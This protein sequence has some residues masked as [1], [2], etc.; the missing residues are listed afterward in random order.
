[1]PPPGRHKQI[2]PSFPYAPSLSPKENLEVLENLI[3]RYGDLQ[4]PEGQTELNQKEKQKNKYRIP[5]ALGYGL[6]A[7]LWLGFTAYVIVE[8]GSTMPK[9]LVDYRVM[10]AMLGTG[11]GALYTPLRVLAKFLFK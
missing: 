4:K 3:S 10:I 2:S 9:F 11:F 8:S 5:F 7:M 6:V 1:M